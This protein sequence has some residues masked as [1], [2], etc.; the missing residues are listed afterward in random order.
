MGIEVAPVRVPGGRPSGRQALGVLAASLALL[1]GMA[2]LGREPAPSPPVPPLATPTLAALAH[3]PA[4]SLRPAPGTTR[5]VATPSPAPASTPAPTPRGGTATI[6]TGTARLLSEAAAFIPS[7]IE[8]L[9]HGPGQYWHAVAATDGAI[10]AQDQGRLTRYEPASGRA[11]TWTVDDDARLL[12]NSI[13][14]AR[15]GGIWLIGMRTLRRFDGIGFREALDVG[16][17]IA[18]VTEARDGSLW[19]ATAGAAL[20][21]IAGTRRVVIGTLRPNPDAAISAIAVDPAGDV[22]CGWVQYSG[23]VGG[24]VARLDGKIWRVFDGADALPLAS[25]VRSIDALPDG[26]VWVLTG[27]GLAR[28]D[29][30]R[31]INLTTGEPFEGVAPEAVATAPDGSFWVL[32]GGRLG[33]FVGDSW[34]PYGVLAGVPANTGDPSALMPTS[35]GIF[36][37]QGGAIY[38]SSAGRWR[39]AWPGRQANGPSGGRLLAISRREVWAADGEG[40]WHFLD[41]SWS[42]PFVPLAG[43]Y[44]RDLVRTRD[45]SLWAAT[46]GGTYRL[47]GSQWTL[48]GGG[49]EATS[50]ALDPRGEL[51]SAGRMGQ[52][53]GWELRSFVSNGRTWS[54]RRRSPATD[55]ITWPIH[56]VFGAD[57]S[58]W[59][60]SPGAW[61]LKPGLV[62][63]VH[64]RWETV[65]PRGGSAEFL[66]LDLA[67]ARDGSVWAAGADLHSS[68]NDTMVGP[69]WISRFDGTGWNVLDPGITPRS[70]TASLASAP[71]GTVWLAGDNGLARSGGASW[72]S[73]YRGMSF[74]AVAVAPDGTVWTSGPSGVARLVASAASP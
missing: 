18:A 22:W 16:A 34:K 67:V 60:G 5:S 73:L 19:V 68:G 47:Q 6:T 21:H 12:A 32:V 33:R 45:G 26:S 14:P 64:G 4:A 1:V 63:F 62:H 9:S 37:E 31:W 10:W 48:V 35:R 7:G 46:D 69:Y 39:P 3:A 41:G 66:V 52:S 59:V 20:V 74:S 58:A 29:T 17:D 56:L 50:L 15:A 49:F 72:T 54:A 25:G 11:R 30:H 55:L 8:T 61:G 53:M 28:F 71:D 65:H 27:T 40:V 2:V 51:W 44:V 42:G 23:P 36:V 38:R 13:M 43:G 24:W 57:R 70:S